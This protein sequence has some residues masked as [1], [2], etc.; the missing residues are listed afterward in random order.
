M[1]EN[2][3]LI[4]Y[5]NVLFKRWKLIAI[6]FVIVVFFAALFSVLKRPVYTAEVTILPSF[7]T[8]SGAPGS[9]YPLSDIA[10][11]LGLSPGEVGIN[12]PLIYEKML[13]SRELIDRVVQ[14]K[15][16]SSRDNKE[17]TLIQI[18]RLDKEKNLGKQLY[19][20]YTT[21]LDGMKVKIDNESMT[22]TL[23]INSKDPNLA[24]IIANA[25]IEELDEYNR[26]ILTI[27]AATNKEFTE[28]RLNDTREKL[29][30]AEEELKIF[31]QENR[32]IED[33]PELSLELGRLLREVK[34]QE[35][36]FI[37]LSRE[38]ELA[39]IQEVKDTPIVYT[40]GKARPPIEKSSPK[41]KLNVLIAA[42]VSL[43]FG[44]G[45]AFLCEYAEKSGWNLDNLENTEG[46][47]V[48]STDFSLF[49]QAIKKIYRKLKRKKGN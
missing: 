17:K 20:A 27:K 13:K 33:S 48:I 40:L 12:S 3:N 15:F 23:Y 39:R 45:A 32:R 34:L 4:Y 19:L 43:I 49:K 5:L 1:D 6:I 46:F 16:I 44:F 31:C 38:F 42:V 35:E 29:R 22:L 7:E 26:E 8:Q 25:I 30:L 21:L 41:R 36:L 2:V 9:L 10:T 37:T 28:D 11:Q 47:K 24:A 18:Y 14:R